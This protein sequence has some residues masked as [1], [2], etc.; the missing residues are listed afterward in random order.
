MP[1]VL[2]VIFHDTN[3]NGISLH[4]QYWMVALLDLFPTLFSDTKGSAQWLRS[5]ARQGTPPVSAWDEASASISITTDRKSISVM[6]IGLPRQSV[7]RPIT[8]NFHSVSPIRISLLILAAT[9]QLPRREVGGDAA[10]H[11]DPCGEEN[12]SPG[13]LIQHSV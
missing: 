4:I 2:Y 9:R 5:T 13:T 12:S 3:E 11:L 7:P 6:G 8:S 10:D 1:Y